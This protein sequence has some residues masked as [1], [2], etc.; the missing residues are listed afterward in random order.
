MCAV[1]CE[2]GVPIS[3]STYYERA[4]KTPTRRQVRKGQLVE[5][6]TAARENIKTGKL[7]KTLGSRKLWIWPAG[8]G[9]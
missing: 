1:L 4:A 5:I 8:P 7:V 2:H 9:P 6:I 3:P